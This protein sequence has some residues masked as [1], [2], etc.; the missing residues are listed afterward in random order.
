MHR[1]ERLDGARARVRAGSNISTCSSRSN[2]ATAGRSCHILWKRQSV[3]LDLTLS[4]VPSLLLAETLS[5]ARNLMETS[6][7]D[8]TVRYAIWTRHYLAHATP[9]CKGRVVAPHR[10]GI[11]PEGV[12]TVVCWRFAT[13][14]GPLPRASGSLFA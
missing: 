11:T 1:P 9:E 10:Y 13:G 6:A 2:S 12:H 8:E 5:A 4:Y 14:R 3:P 7:L